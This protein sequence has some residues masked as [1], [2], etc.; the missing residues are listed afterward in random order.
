MKYPE[1]PNGGKSNSNLQY[2]TVVKN[3]P[4]LKALFYGGTPARSVSYLL[5]ATSR[6]RMLAPAAEDTASGPWARVSKALPS[7]FLYTRSLQVPA[8]MHELKLLA[9]WCS[10]WISRGLE[11]LA[12]ARRMYI[13][14]AFAQVLCLLQFC[15]AERTMWPHASRV[16]L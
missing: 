7:I 10:A 3:Y 6:E 14:S 8:S 13:E 2:R 12:S 4:S 5:K 9:Q 15:Q 11:N 1:Q 16:L